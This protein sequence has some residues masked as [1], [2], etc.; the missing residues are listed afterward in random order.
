MVS[1]E[2]GDMLAKVSGARDAPTVTIGAQALRGYSAEL[3][4]SYLDSAGYPRESRLPPSYQ[5]RPVAPVVE[6]R[7]QPAAR[8][9]SPAP[10]VRSNP[11]IATTAPPAP[12][13]IRF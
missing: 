11:P 9:D 10:V 3:W 7:E 4:N 6:R 12:G 5:Q 13:G 1:P 2:D 8:A